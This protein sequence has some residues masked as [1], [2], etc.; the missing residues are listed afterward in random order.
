MSAAVPTALCFWF[1]AVLSEGAP[2]L[3]S[4][5]GSRTHWRQM[6]VPLPEAQRAPLHPGS[7]VTLR[8]MLAAHDEF[9]VELVP[10]PSVDDDDVDDVDDQ[11]EEEGVCKPCT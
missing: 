10:L 6:L 3:S 9:Q 2:T 7:Q 11:E 8:A 1:E 5:P 4:S